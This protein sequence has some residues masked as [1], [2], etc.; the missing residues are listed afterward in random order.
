MSRSLSASYLNLIAAACV[1]FSAAATTRAQTFTIGTQGTTANVNNWPMNEPPARAID[2]VGQKYLNFAKLN[3]GVAV[4]SAA[5][6]VPTSIT[7]WAANDAVA[8]DPSTFKIYG[9]SSPAS[10]AAGSSIGGLS[11][12]ASGAFSLPVDRTPGG[13]A[14]LGAFSS[15]ATFANA[16][17]YP[18][19]VIV[20]PTVKDAV[21]AN[22]M[23]V[24]EIQMNTS[25][26]AGLFTPNDAVV[27]GVLVPEPSTAILG[28]LGLALA[29]F[30]R[31]R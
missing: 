20:F 6:G 8:R 18:T 13:N 14:A 7:V 12:I 3:T 27:G 10:G 28:G 26:G 9:T 17:A 1:L 31:R 4:S 29:A 22:S 2:G 16:T 15:T 5:G 23:Q 24:A 21:G 11:L 30:R 19:Y 25:G